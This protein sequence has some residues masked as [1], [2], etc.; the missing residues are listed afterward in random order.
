MHNREGLSQAHRGP[1][2]GFTFKFIRFEIDLKV[3]L[4]FK[5]SKENIERMKKAYAANKATQSPPKK[6]AKYAK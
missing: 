2:Q 1:C 6:K 3:I 5:V 4:N